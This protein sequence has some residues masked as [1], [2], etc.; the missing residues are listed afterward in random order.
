M[1]NTLQILRNYIPLLFLALLPCG[2]AGQGAM[3]SLQTIWRN[4][5]K[6]YASRVDALMEA[7]KMLYRK[8]RIDSC[9]ILWR[10]AESIALTYQDSLLLARAWAG[11][12]QLHLLKGEYESVD[13]LTKRSLRIFIKQADSSWIAKTRINIGNLRLRQN[14]YP[15]A[16]EAYSN[17]LSIAQKLD[18]IELQGRIFSN[19]GIIEEEQAHYEEAI[20][21]YEK[22]LK[23]KEKGDDE[24]STGRTCM[25]IGVV[26]ARQEEFGQA[27]AW[28][29][30]SVKHFEHA[31]AKRQLSM[32]LNN[33]ASMQ[34]AQGN[35]G[36]AIAYFMKAR[37]VFEQ[38]GD[39]RSLGIC[40]FNIGSLYSKIDDYGMA[41]AFLKESMN[42]FVKLGHTRGEAMAL[43][44]MGSNY[45][46]AG[47]LDS[48]F[49]SLNK[50]LELYLSI[51]D[52]QGQ[53]ECLAALGFAFLSQ[54]K[55]G[56]SREYYEQALR[57]AEEI[58][59][60]GSMINCLNNISYTWILQNRWDKAIAY[61]T[62]G[63]ER[64]RQQADKAEISAAAKSLWKSYKAVGKD[65]EALAMHELFVDTRDSLQQEEN[66]RA[67]L[68]QEFE[69][70]YQQKALSDSLAFVQQQ[71]SQELAFQ[72]R[73]IRRNYLM[74]GAA[75]MGLLALLF[76]RYRHN[77]KA[78]VRA[79]LLE[80]ERAEAERLRQID[81]LKTR[82]YNNI[83]HEFRTPLTVIQGMAEEAQRHF[84][85]GDIAAFEH[86][87][88]MIQRNGGNMLHLVN[89][90]LDLARLE[91]GSLE[92]DYVHA[93]VIAYLSYIC[94][95]FESYADSQNIQLITYKE[96]N[97]L[98][99]DYEPARLLSI[100]SN[101]LS[102]AIKFT[103]AGG[104]VIFHISRGEEQL[105]IKVQ[106]NGRGME[107]EA[108]PHIFDR[109]FQTN[110]LVKGEGS[111]IGLA[112]AKELVQA[113][114]G[115]ISVQS[116]SEKGSI[117]TVKLPIKSSAREAI[118]EGIP[119]RVK[120][121]VLPF[122]GN[123][124]D[125]TGSAEPGNFGDK[126]LILI[127]EDNAD[128]QYYL[129]QCLYGDYRCLIANDGREGIAGATTEVPDLV[130]SDVMMP[131]VDGFELCEALKADERT[132]H[133]PIILL[134]A[135]ASVE[136]RIAGLRKGADAYLAKPFNREELRVSIGNL[137]SQRLRLR[138]RYSGSAIDT[139]AGLESD[140]DLKL[141]D[142]FVAKFRDFVLAQLDNSQLGV[143]DLCREMGLSRTQLH[144]K[145]K[146]LTGLSTSRLVRNIR[147]GEAR[148]LLQ[149]ESMS[150]SEIAWHCG[151]A[152]PGYFSRVFSKEFG[153][154]PTEF[155]E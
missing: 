30:R 128:V 140:V 11:I 73:L 10:Q 45:T 108:L 89:Q 32:A 21:L 134:T 3:D 7:G 132:S 104:K 79:L 101:L 23:I 105:I 52:K 155:R 65:K 12:Q 153:Q 142:A 152:D 80:Q 26:Y 72:T 17:A 4:E 113:M 127:V 75:A 63:L 114:N 43:Q 129:Q 135:R 68:R 9:E 110:Q 33:M 91:S 53:M 112:L 54:E 28:L 69:Y 124:P 35:Y 51:S 120:Q 84:D 55:P 102:N 15:R 16:R 126:P 149:E 57:L 49:F 150:I 103:P 118:A 41:K 14:D 141:E 62:K 38:I 5:A 70:E 121:Q 6:P 44:E 18:D 117:F 137:L 24:V 116:E 77:R 59:A 82:L 36:Q 93:D 1:N 19:L 154:S 94:E 67:I 61:G 66:R 133:I 64:A 81:E 39:Q 87:I 123:K 125:Q 60:K 95:S 71:A 145:L 99:M 46:L 100:V 29:E 115:N 2:L 90:M 122:L 48:A 109:F 50:G 151:F 143:E 83:T 111:G 76:L 40:L 139:D 58:G 86:A 34:K 98:S 92:L 78:R 42:T 13:S 25:N 97:H 8:N 119:A 37:T 106:D 31:G 27:L 47:Q 138:L 146:A 131:N 136:D 56:K 144:R 85:Q 96:V 20:Q 107:P 147:L 88:S 130:I 148:K 74:W 22:S